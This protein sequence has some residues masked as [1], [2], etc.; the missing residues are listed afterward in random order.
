M[1]T[2][3][4]GQVLD[5][6][7]HRSFEVIQF[8]HDHMAAIEAVA[9][10]LTPVE[11][12]EDFR[13]RIAALYAKLN[14]LVA[15]SEIIIQITPAG[16]AMITADDAAAQR[17]LLG[18][19]TAALRPEEYFAK[20]TDLA[21]LQALL[22]S[23]VA[24]L[25]AMIEGILVRLD[26]FVT[27]DELG[28]AAYQ[29]SDAFASAAQLASLQAAVDALTLLVNGILLQLENFVTHDQLTDALANLTD[30][31]DGLDG[32]NG[33][34]RSQYEQLIVDLGNGVY[35]SAMASALDEL[36]ARII[37]NEDGVTAIAQHTVTLETE[38]HTLDGQLSGHSLAIEQLTSSVWTNGTDIAAIASN[39]I[40]LSTQ[41]V[42][43]NEGVAAQG[44][45][46]QSLETRTSLIEGT[47]S[48]QSTLLTQLDATVQDTRFNAELTAN[49]LQ[50]LTATVQSNAAGQLITADFTTQLNSRLVDTETGQIEQATALDGLSTRVEQ[51]E[52]SLVIASEERT[53]LQASLTSVG[54]LL[55][56]PS[57]E[58]DTRGWTFFSHGAGWLSATLGRDLDAVTALPA[59]CH[60]LSLTTVGVPSG[61]AGIC[62]ANL[63]IEALKRYIL[64]GYLGAINATGRL[65]YRLLNA[66]LEEI[67]FGLVGT[68]GGPA[69]NLADWTRVHAEI[70]V[71]LDAALI[72]I[73]WWVDLCNTTD[74]KAWLLRPMLEEAVAG[75]VNP[76]PWVPGIAGMDN[77]FASAVQELNARI[78]ITNG[79][80]T[81][82]ANALTDLDV[83]LG[84]KADAAALTLLETRVDET[85]DALTSQSSS[86]TDLSSRVGTLREWRVVAYGG[87][88]TWEETQAPMEAGL[89]SLAGVSAYTFLRGLT[90]VR[91]NLAGEFDAATRFDTF[92]SGAA[93]TA[94]ADALSA[95]TNRDYFMLVG[96]I[97]HG[98][99][100][101]DLTL[102]M[103][104]CGAMDCDNVNGSIPYLLFGRGGIGKGAGIEVF[105]TG[106]DNFIDHVFTLVN[107]IPKGMGERAGLV[108]TLA[109]QATA[110]S[111]LTTRVE[112][113][114]NGLDVVSSDVTE[115]ETRMVDAE[116][117]LAAQATAVSNLT[118]RVTDAE[119]EITALST[120]ST[121][122]GSQVDTMQS[123]LIN[124]IITSANKDAAFASS[125]NNLS[126]RMLDAEGDVA[127]NTSAIGTLT[128]QVTS[129]GNTIATHS[130]SLTN[131]QN[132]V[133]AMDTGTGG[134][135]AAISGL[136]VRI[137]ATEDSIDSMSSDITTLQNSVTSAN[138]VFAQ[139]TAP[140]LVGRTD[141]D[142]WIDTDD[143]NKL[144][145]YSAASNAWMPRM[146]SGKN[147]VFVQASAPTAKAVNDIWFDS[148]D[149]FKM[150]RWNGT[151]WVLTSD[152][153]ILANSSAIT[154]LTSRVT[155]AEGKI[156]SQG[157]AITTLENTV[158]SA[159]GV[160]NTAS[161]VSALTTRVTAA[162]GVNTSQ[163]G[164]ITTLQNTVNN[165][166]TG[167]A[168]TASGLS[169]LTTRV[170]AAEGVNT[171]Q[172]SAIT[173]LQNTV[174]NA[175]TGV[176]ATANALTALTTRVTAAEGVNTSQAAALT[177]LQSTVNN[178][179]TGVAA[180]ATALG[181]LTTRV[182]AA[183]GVNTSQASAI[184]NLTS[185][186]N[187]GTTGVAAT[188]SALSTLTTRVTSVE[189]V[190]TSQASSLT[191]LSTTVSGHTASINSHATSINGLMASVGI[192]LDVDGYIT[193]WSLNNNGDSGEF[194]VRADKFSIVKPG[195]GARLEYSANNMR[196]YDAAGVMRVRLGV[197]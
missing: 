118:T 134:Y 91:F 14:L 44:V 103:E 15:A 128:T 137:T 31:L 166:T 9:S 102:A 173:S 54:N 100:Q 161:A 39:V 182:T 32:D 157:A 84:D 178:G 115:L 4:P 131:L 82:L 71:P 97:H 139:P 38:L 85:E 56:N 64:S 122:L 147:S 80:V 12:L 16:F 141:G 24:A 79:D 63:P 120:A 35:V 55:E 57:F 144:Y 5:H 105:A 65:E 148:D 19:G 159:T 172:G 50:A 68:S 33:L 30:R 149:T 117:G 183:E 138:K 11:D 163:S 195:G 94:L 98:I 109:G 106:G 92:A 73:Q 167:V 177:T 179:T 93:R 51:T 41:I 75:Q 145:T 70:L 192:D 40:D 20:A 136:D 121:A 22:E 189:G 193:G 185:T 88:D 123:A 89:Y 187:N 7:L 59:G 52:D 197:W 130:S 90:L 69:G 169:A 74:P 104:A 46:Y 113:T 180:T 43:L 107:D 101:A 45:A 146:D 119:G 17:D 37:V 162:E 99:K 176:V 27:R 48:S 34:I 53:V 127:A 42:S 186:V 28:S 158:N 196:V 23:E 49:A 194:Q 111:G 36:T 86:L 83:A 60:A 18:L 58:A 171:S 3:A 110:V 175:G 108:S 8:V 170:T 155:T 150:Y 29:D 62:S 25:N 132:Q 67:Q 78:D 81:V 114:E 61:A 135:G 77:M 13:E 152:T 160:V 10:H 190:N 188:A 143:G 66:D 168:A 129:Q 125:I 191:T 184:T 153:R 154:A 151:S 165:A 140:S 164:L 26:T 126:A 21:A 156:T 96:H 174:N 116:S 124:E 181:A 1:T 87:F 112:A 76:S 2:A 142:I 72:Q 6:Y 133:N 95:L 47:V